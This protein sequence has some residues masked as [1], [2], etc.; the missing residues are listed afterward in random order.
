MKTTT[1]TVRTSYFITS[2]LEPRYANVPCHPATVPPC[3][4]HRRGLATTQLTFCFLQLK[5]A[6]MFLE[7]APLVAPSTL[8]LPLP[9]AV[10]D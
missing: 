4:H 8:A 7:A 6:T 3:H 9:T 10:A 1:M 2:Y 5:Q